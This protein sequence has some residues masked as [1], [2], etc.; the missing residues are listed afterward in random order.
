MK[1]ILRADIPTL[2]EGETAICLDSSS[3]IKYTAYEG[4]KEQSLKDL[5]KVPVAILEEIRDF[6]NDAYQ[7]TALIF[8][9][10]FVDQGI[11]TKVT[12][13]N[14]T[15][16]TAPA[17]PTK[18]GYTFVNWL[19]DEEAFSFNTLITSNITLNSNFTVNEYTITFDSDGGSAV[20]AITQDYG[21]EITAPDDPTLADFVFDGWDVAIP[22]T[23]PAGNITITATWVAAE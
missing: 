13:P 3:I 9:V 4:L 23:M 1:F 20:E 11:T 6:L 7:D 8:R 18:T 22:T 10:S 17:D 14:N 16:V 15:K 12:V 21:T 2:V 5:S 19:L